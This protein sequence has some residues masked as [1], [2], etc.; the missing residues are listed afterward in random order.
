MPVTKVFLLGNFTMLSS[1]VALII[2]FVI[3]Y[4]AVRIRYGKKQGAYLLDLYFYIVI[5]WKLS[6]IITDFSSVIR[7][8]LSIFYFHGGTVGFYLGLAFV[9]GKIVVDWKK[10]RPTIADPIAL[11]T[12]AIVSQVVY[13]VM[14]VVLNEGELVAQ[15]VT[16]SAFMSFAILF[17]FSIRKA[18]S[19]P[20]QLTFIFMAVHV[21]VSAFQ[22]KGF[23]ETP[24]ITT[25]LIGLFFT[26][27]LMMKNSESQR[28]EE[29]L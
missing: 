12:A 28:T 8:P 14:M 9:M 24:F 23:S 29:Q 17:W 11:L 18:D 20:L 1:W 22:P 25:L 4:S 2:A 13:Q 19:W 3:A 21:F 5:I 6:V 7:S 16:V 27:V 10:E 15:V 26:A